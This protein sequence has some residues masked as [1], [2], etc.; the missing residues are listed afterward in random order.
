MFFTLNIVWFW[1]A[2]Q[3]KQTRCEKYWQ[4]TE[5]EAEISIQFLP[6]F[7]LYSLRSWESLRKC[8]RFFS[9]EESNWSNLK[10]VKGP[11]MSSSL[12]KAVLYQ[13]LY[14]L[15][16]CFS[17]Q[18]VMRKWGECVVNCWALFRAIDSDTWVMA[19]SAALFLSN[20]DNG[21]YARF[22]SK[23]NFKLAR[24]KQWRRIPEWCATATTAEMKYWTEG[25]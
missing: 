4:K 10:Y 8:G 19:S 3:G 20:N 14:V 15:L 13:S 16:V 17:V 22:Q 5:T 7:S 11:F 21:P 12:L 2:P 25:I 6:F 23:H 9:P 1:E 24:E 18:I